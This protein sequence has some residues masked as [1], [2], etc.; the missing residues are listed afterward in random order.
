MVGGDQLFDVGVVGELVG[1]VGHEHFL[2][3]HQ[4]PVVTVEGAVEDEHVII[5]T[6]ARGTG[7]W[8]VIRQVRC[9]LDPALPRQVLPGAAWLHQRVGGVTQHHCFTG[10]PGWR[11]VHQFHLVVGVFG[12]DGFAHVLVDRVADV[13]LT[14]GGQGRHTSGI[15]VP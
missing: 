6:R 1:V 10:T 15:D 8:G 3:A 2:L 13:G 11:G 5:G 9:K 4:R 14:C 12:A 7:V